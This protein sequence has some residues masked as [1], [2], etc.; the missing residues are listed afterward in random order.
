[1]EELRVELR[2]KTFTLD[3]E[4]LGI[5]LEIIE[6]KE[7]KENKFRKLI[8]KYHLL[9]EIFLKNLNNI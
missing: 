5:V 4:K 3:K 9:D 8:K 1:M 6:G 7:I 2:N